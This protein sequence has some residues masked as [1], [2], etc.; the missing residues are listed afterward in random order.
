MLFA[1]SAGCG[2]KDGDKAGGDKG[3]ATAPSGGGGTD[4]L[5][6]AWT[7]K[8]GDKNVYTFNA[9]KSGSRVYKEEAPSKFTWSV[10]GD[11]VAIEFPAEGDTQAAKFTG[12][13]DCGK[14]SFFL[15][16]G[17]EFRKL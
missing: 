13:I 15:D 8:F 14:T 4:C 10:S 6:G 1:G 9:D 7:N 2:K 3:A 5:V 12:S 11:K 17:G 16:G